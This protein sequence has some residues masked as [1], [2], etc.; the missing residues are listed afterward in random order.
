[1]K[2]SK[3]SISDNFGKK[4]KNG[5]ESSGAG[6]AENSLYLMFRPL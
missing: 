5:I 1:M 4:A 3:M 6:T 2:K